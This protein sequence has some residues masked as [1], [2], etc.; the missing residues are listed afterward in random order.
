MSTEALKE[1]ALPFEPPAHR[2]FQSD[3]W[4]CKGLYLSDVCLAAHVCVQK[5]NG[6]WQ[7]AKD[8]LRGL[9][10]GLGLIVQQNDL[11]RPVIAVVED[12]SPETRR[13]PA[14]Q[15]WHRGD[16]LLFVVESD[17][18]ERRLLDLLRPGD[19]LRQ[20]VEP[21][22]IEPRDPAWFRQALIDRAGTDGIA[23]YVRHLIDLLLSP[24]DG[25][26]AAARDED[27]VKNGIA[28]WAK[29]LAETAERIAKGESRQ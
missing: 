29:G 2:I 19:R 18:I 13:L 1:Y 12:A 5:G 6:E 28:D 11:W 8:D 10:R 16:F 25:R 14:D 4:I 22:Q 9:L 26:G 3:Y 24:H 21:E 7:A 15:D 20:L 23:V 27:S 17:Q